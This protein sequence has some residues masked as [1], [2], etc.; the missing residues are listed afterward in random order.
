V[1][2]EVDVLVQKAAWSQSTWGEHCVVSA[3]PAASAVHVPSEVPPAFTEQA[4]QSVVTPPLHALSQQTPSTQ[5]P[6]AQVPS[7]L[8]G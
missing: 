8:Q 2:Q 7:A 4:W 3:T 1:G 6:E 5:C